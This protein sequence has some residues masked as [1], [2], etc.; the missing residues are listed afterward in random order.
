MRARVAELAG[1]GAYGELRAFLRGADLALLARGWRR[2]EPLHKLVA[3]KLMSAAAAL[4]LFARL[5]YEERYFLYCGL[6]AASI[7]PIL[8]RAAPAER[9]LFVQLPAPLQRRMFESLAREVPAI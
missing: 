4:E 8:E 9:R 3:F 6:P 2:L 7:A 5:P 1:A